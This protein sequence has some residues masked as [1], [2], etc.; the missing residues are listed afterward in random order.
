MGA[1]EA[2][3]SALRDALAIIIANIFLPLVAR[4]VGIASLTMLELVTKDF[5]YEPNEIV[6]IAGAAAT[7]HGCA[8]SLL[9]ATIKEPLRAEIHN[10]IRSVLKVFKCNVK[11]NIKFCIFS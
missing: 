8:G 2:E 4:C 10:A 1:I 3:K 7:A 9:L 6:F 11:R 5:G